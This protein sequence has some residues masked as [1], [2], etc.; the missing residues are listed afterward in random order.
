MSGSLPKLPMSGGMPY[1]ATAPRC[2]SICA[3]TRRIRPR[4]SVLFP[5]VVGAS[6]QTGVM[7]KDR[8]RREPRR[9]RKRTKETLSEAPIKVAIATTPQTST[10]DRRALDQDTEL[11]KAALLYAD[12]VELVSL[13][14]SMFDELRQVIDAGEMGGYGLLASL[15]DD[16]INYIA[17]RDG[18]ENTLPPELSPR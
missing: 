6:R 13:G 12:E 18:S 1:P 11:T 16:T 2:R 3:P 9:D 5:H 8:K 15:D 14:M 10:G 7:A 17:T 4:S